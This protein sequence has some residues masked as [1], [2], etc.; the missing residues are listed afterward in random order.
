MCAQR[1]PQAAVRNPVRRLSPFRDVVHRRWSVLD[2]TNPRGL[3]GP[4][5]VVAQGVDTG[6]QGRNATSVGFDLVVDRAS[7]RL[8]RMRTTPDTPLSRGMVGASTVRGFRRQLATLERGRPSEALL[9]HLLA[10]VPGTMIVAAYVDLDRPAE[11]AAPSIDAVESPHLAPANA[12]AGWVDGG[13]LL[14]R[15]EAAGRPVAIAGPPAPRLWADLQQPTPVSTRRTRLIEVASRDAGGL[16]VRSHFRDTHAA[17]DGEETVIHEYL[18]K[19]S[20]DAELTIRAVEAKPRVLPA[21]ECPL[22]TARVG[23]LVGNSLASVHRVV[24]QEF[25]GTSGCTHLSDMLRSV[26][27]TGRLWESAVSD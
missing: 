25:G 13:T 5:H 9:H 17:A 22:V 20:L 23:R 27:S 1:S 10:D 6:L 26:A 18:L 11:E 19:V 16:E 3:D 2:A 8:R 21:P 4:V 14:R 7:R 12:C 24:A 15:V